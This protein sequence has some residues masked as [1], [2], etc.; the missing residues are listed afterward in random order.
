MDALSRKMSGDFRNVAQLDVV[1]DVLKAQGWSRSIRDDTSKV[2][3][4]SG[5]EVVCFF[6]IHFFLQ[7][8]ESFRQEEAT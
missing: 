3:E 6:Q 7:S 4:L 5:G 8:F 2:V 1:E